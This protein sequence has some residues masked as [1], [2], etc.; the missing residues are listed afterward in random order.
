MHLMD[1]LV[2]SMISILNLSP[3][4]ESLLN[5]EFEKSESTAVP[6]AIG[7]EVFNSVF[8]LVDGIYPR[9]S[10]FV[11]GM[12]E[13]ATD[14]EKTFTEWQEAVRKDIE[15]AFGN[16]QGRFQALATPIMLMDLK[17]MLTF[18]LRH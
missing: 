11:K 8:I 4:L 6:F 3:F 7:Q 12:K 2:H 5:G 13:P 9:Y 18:A 15:R 16:L 10:R 17:I 14:D 1:M